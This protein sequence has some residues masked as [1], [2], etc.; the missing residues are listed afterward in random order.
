MVAAWL[1]NAV[2]L[3]GPLTAREAFELVGADSDRAI[4]AWRRLEGRH[5]INK[6]P[7]GRWATA[8]QLRDLGLLDRRVC[9]SPAIET[10]PLVRETKP[11]AEPP[12]KTVQ[13]SLF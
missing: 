5:E 8:V 11:A 9:S 3:R 6:L 1:F 10:Q 4:E 12:R 7:D 13:R 2:A